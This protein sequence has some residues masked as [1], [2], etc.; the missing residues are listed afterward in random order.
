[1]SRVAPA[2]PSR[3]GRRLLGA[4]ALLASVV[5]LRAL[6]RRWP[7]PQPLPPHGW[8]RSDRY[9]W[10]GHEVRFQHTGD[11]PPLVLVHSLGPGHDS[12]EWERAAE[13]LGER[14]EVVAPD[15][16]GWGVSHW[17]REGTPTAQVYVDFLC[18]FLAEVVHQ[19]TVLVAAGSAAPFA[20]AAAARLGRERVRALALVG[21]RGLPGDGAP[22]DARTDL[23]LRAAALPALLP[24]ARRALTT[25]R[26]IQRHLERDVFAAPERADAV[27]RERSY[28]A[29]RQRGARPA[30]S[31]WLAGRLE[32]RVRD[33]LGEL[34]MPVWLAWGRRSRAPVVEAADRWVR[35]LPEAE[36]EV[37]EGTG[38]LP[39][40]EAPVT[41]CRALDTF[42]ERALA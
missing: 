18:D 10:R 26:A 14:W 8:G 16:P 7:R 29:A 3:G 1:M 13:L 17:R 6:L 19:P 22:P 40:A 11:G 34:S 37:F 25:R 12:A 30:L 9:L 5:G 42:L 28:R 36:L 23:L 38:A 39:H 15:L 31:A 32:L 24:F 4:L 35:G 21:P 20:V 2:S 33:L 27:R 41:F